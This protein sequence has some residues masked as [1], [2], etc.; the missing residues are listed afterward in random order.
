MNVMRGVYTELLKKH[1]SHRKNSLYLY[2]QLTYC[3]K[4]PYIKSV[5]FNKYDHCDIW[6]SH[7]ITTWSLP[8]TQISSFY[9]LSSIYN[10]KSK[11]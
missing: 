10:S 3:K 5:S 8:P 11:A 4:G 2:Y 1:R 7:F 9:V 6:T